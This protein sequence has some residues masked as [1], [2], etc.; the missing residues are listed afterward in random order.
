M[1]PASLT[2]LFQYHTATWLTP[3]PKSPETYGWSCVVSVSWKCSGGS[4]S[5]WSRSSPSVSA[6]FERNSCLK[7]SLHS[8]T[9]P[10]VRPEM[11]WDC[12]E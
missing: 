7:V 11:I 10:R 8:F 2:F 4:Y 1:I 3:F 5:Y 12:K 9:A 6:I